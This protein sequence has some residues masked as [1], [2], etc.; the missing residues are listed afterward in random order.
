MLP[1]KIQFSLRYFYHIN[2]YEPKIVAND[3]H[4]VPKNNQ[5]ESILEMGMET[6]TNEKKKLTPESR[7]RIISPETKHMNGIHYALCTIQC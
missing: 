6:A 4:I 7:Q 1:N 3:F 5:L 2:N